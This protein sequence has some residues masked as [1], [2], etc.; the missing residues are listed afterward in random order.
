MPGMVFANDATDGRQVA[1]NLRPI[2]HD[3]IKCRGSGTR[4]L[5]STPSAAAAPRHVFAC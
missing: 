1:M 2:A 4:K 5:R 3:A